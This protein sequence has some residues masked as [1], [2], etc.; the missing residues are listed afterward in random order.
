[1]NQSLFCSCW[2]ISSTSWPSFRPL[3]ATI[4]HH[5]HAPKHGTFLAP[6]SKHKI[7]FH[8]SRASFLFFLIGSWPPI[9]S[10]RYK[11][12]IRRLLSPSITDECGACRHPVALGEKSDSHNPWVVETHLHVSLAVN[13]YCSADRS[14]DFHRMFVISMTVPQPLTILLL[15]NGW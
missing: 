13:D 3:I 4:F 11:H 12:S 15:L 14:R 9:F 6:N 7:T 2:S 1:M 5:P 10:P 8:F